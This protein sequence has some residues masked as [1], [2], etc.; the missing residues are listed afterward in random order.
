MELR[1]L[2]ILVAGCR[3]W[4]DMLEELIDWFLVVHVDE[5]MELMGN[6]ICCVLWDAGENENVLRVGCMGLLSMCNDF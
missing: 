4:V 1:N 5:L 3:D 2:L 6:G